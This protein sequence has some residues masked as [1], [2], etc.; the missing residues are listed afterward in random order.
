MWI[1]F[2]FM[3][4]LFAGI[5]AVLSK[6]G[7]QKT[8]SII[9]T[10]FRTIVILICSWGMVFIVGSQHM[11]KEISLKTWVFLILS[12]FATEHHG[13]VILKHYNLGISIR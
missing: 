4:S 6:C 12:G 9:A 11:I 2:A 10:A 13:Y 8:N 5:T 7:I 1:V 3:S